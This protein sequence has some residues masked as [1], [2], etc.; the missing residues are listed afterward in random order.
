MKFLMLLLSL[1]LSIAT[2]SVQALEAGKDYA[3]LSPTQKT[4][5]P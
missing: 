5:A 2:S 3:E 1:G 4:S